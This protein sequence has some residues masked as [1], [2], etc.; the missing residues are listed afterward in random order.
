MKKV[1]IFLVIIM[2]MGVLAVMAQSSE[3]PGVDRRQRHQRAR[4]REG[5][6]SGE[7]TRKEAAVSRRDQRKVR[8]TERRAKADGEVTK[9]ERAVIHHKQNKASRKLRRNKHDE[10]QRPAT[11]GTN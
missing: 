9:K 3:T 2:F 1:R 4:I 11:T 6:G 10:Q 8:R 7:L 5:V